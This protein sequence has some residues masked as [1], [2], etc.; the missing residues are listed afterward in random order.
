M[1]GAEPHLG[2]IVRGN[3]KLVQA[4]WQREQT[5][6]SQPLITTA[7][8]KLMTTAVR[9]GRQD[10]TDCHGLTRLLWDDVAKYLLA[11]VIKVHAKAVVEGGELPF[12]LRAGIA[13]SRAI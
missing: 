3:G 6:D 4:C 7:G 12:V 9:G 2:G 8:D 5:V 10:S 1:V 11:I 13:T